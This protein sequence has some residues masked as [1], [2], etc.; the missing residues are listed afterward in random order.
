MAENAIIRMDNFNRLFPESRFGPADLSRKFGRRTSF[1]TDL[2]AGRK[3]FGEKL[4]RSIEQTAE[5]APG[6]LDEPQGARKMLF[7][8]DLMAHLE[9][10]PEDARRKAE[11]LL[12]LHLGIDDQ[13]GKLPDAA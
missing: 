10:L 9:S 12:R 11:A 8:A 4:A 1:W 7:S 3:S 13:S 2:R 5:L 6:S